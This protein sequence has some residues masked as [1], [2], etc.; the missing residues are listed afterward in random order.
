MGEYQRSTRECTLEDMRPELKTAINEHIERYG[1]E[2]VIASAIYCCEA[3]SIKEKK[4]LFGSKTEVEIRGTVLTP[5]WLITAGGRE[6]GDMG[7]FSARLQE[8]RVQDY[9]KTKMYKMI[10]DTGLNV[11]GFPTGSGPGSIFIGLGTEPAAQ[12]FREMLL[13]N[14]TL[15]RDGR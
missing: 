6:N 9:E 13:E 3:V 15:Q 1:L 14:I 4:K 11:Y 8:L 2:D 5:K 7:A 12:R 10:A